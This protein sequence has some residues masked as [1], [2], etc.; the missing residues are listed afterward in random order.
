MAMHG[1]SVMR[2]CHGPRHGGLSWLEV[3][4]PFPPKSVDVD[5]DGTGFFFR[6]VGAVDGRPRGGPGSVICG[7]VMG[8]PSIFSEHAG[9]FSR[10]WDCGS[11]QPIWA[12]L[13][14]MSD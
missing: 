6:P 10:F 13:I 4:P 9:I 14:I 11:R 5:G 2:S 3:G 7:D 8:K 1:E 12:D